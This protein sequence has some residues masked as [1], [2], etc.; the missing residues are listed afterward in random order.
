VVHVVAHDFDQAVKILSALVSWEI[1]W[2]GVFDL[3]QESVVLCVFGEHLNDLQNDGDEFAF[4]GFGFA[5][6][7][8]FEPETQ[9]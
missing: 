6:V 3:G 2:V 8:Y 1:A 7:G 4:E 9:D 5:L